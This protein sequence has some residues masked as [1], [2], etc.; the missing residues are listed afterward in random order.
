MYCV[1]V[2]TCMCV[3]VLCVYVCVLYPDAQRSSLFKICDH[4][5]KCY[6]LHLKIL[7]LD[8][9]EYVLGPAECSSG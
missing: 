8:S 6:N 1:Y 4:N 5:W 2:Y 3:Y 9:E 7:V